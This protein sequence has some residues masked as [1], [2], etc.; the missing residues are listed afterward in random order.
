MAITG[1]IAAVA[2]VGS[3]VV[4]NQQKQKAKG[5]AGEIERDAKAAQDAADAKV[6]QA[7][8][9]NIRAQSQAGAVARGALETQ[10]PRSSTL[11]SPDLKSSNAAPLAA[12][13]APV[14]RKTLLGQ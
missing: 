11:I 14:Q 3:M 9:D 4:G 1:T 5:K 7:H 12:P 6:R 13:L 10:T 2:T 8:D